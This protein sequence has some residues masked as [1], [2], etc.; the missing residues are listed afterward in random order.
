M[1][2]GEMSLLSMQHG[3]EGRGIKISIYRQK[4]P[5]LSILQKADKQTFGYPGEWYPAH[6][7]VYRLL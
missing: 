4:I 1:V 5:A 6:H 2:L 3:K 7:G